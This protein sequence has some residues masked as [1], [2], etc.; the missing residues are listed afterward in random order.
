MIEAN[1]GFSDAIWKNY[2]TPLR[3]TGKV[4]VLNAAPARLVS[5]NAS[6]SA[7]EPIP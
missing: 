6:R 1:H 4:V 2:P 7:S 3:M 5:H